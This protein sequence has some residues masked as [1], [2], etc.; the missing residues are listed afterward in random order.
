MPR[1]RSTDLE[2]FQ[3]WLETTVSL[4]PSTTSVYASHVRAT[5]PWL[6]NLQDEKAVTADFK[7]MSADC[8]RKVLSGRRT[9]WKRFGDYALAMKDIKL[10]QPARATEHKG[11]AAL[12]HE[13][14]AAV[15]WLT[16]ENRF[17]HRTI[18]LLTWA[19]VKQ[20]GAAG[21]GALIWNPATPSEQIILPQEHLEAIQLYALGTLGSDLP[22][23]PLTPGSCVPYPW[24]TLR[25]ELRA[26][27]EAVGLAAMQ[28][29]WEVFK[30]TKE[31]ASLSLEHAALQEQEQLKRK[32][33]AAQQTGQAPQETGY[34]TAGLRA[35]IEGNLDTPYLCTAL[36][37]GTPPPAPAAPPQA[38]AA[39]P[40]SRKP[41]EGGEGAALS[42][43]RPTPLLGQS[44]ILQSEAAAG[45]A[46]AAGGGPWGGAGC[47]ADDDV[48]EEDNS[49]DFEEGSG[50]VEESSEDFE[51]VASEVE[52]LLDP[53]RG[54]LPYK[55]GKKKVEVVCAICHHPRSQHIPTRR[56]EHVINNC[57][58]E[59]GYPADA[60][61]MCNGQCPGRHV[62]TPVEG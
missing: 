1:P 13:V 18:P 46:G 20:N 61:S 36:G 35:L 41:E 15:F 23:L 30:H 48:D 21:N 50:D 24:F 25:R 39:R 7:L 52:V 53:S 49:E 32:Q 56:G 28:E 17:K 34:S 3:T 42:S 44:F 11:P 26:Y 43:A 59:N 4:D 40:G 12:P 14:R 19:L 47:R 33:Y 38:A 22:F 55:R 45:F 5:I 9:A 16:T 2:E 8:S 6:S 58:E 60:C 37:G 57:A 27:R 62:F 54:E 10:A 29:N 31:G 51:E